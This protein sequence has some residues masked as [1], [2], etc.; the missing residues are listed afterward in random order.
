MTW[1]KVYKV[2]VS[3]Y[4]ISRSLSTRICPFRALL[5]SKTFKKWKTH[6]HYRKT[7][8]SRWALETIVWNKRNLI[9]HLVAKKKYLVVTISIKVRIPKSNTYPSILQIR[10]F[11]ELKV[12]VRILKVLEVICFWQARMIR[13]TSL[14]LRK[15]S[16]IWKCSSISIIWRFNRILLHESMTPLTKMGKLHLKILE[17]DQMIARWVFHFQVSE[18]NLT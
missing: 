2:R 14:T 18:E 16:T 9:S 1:V 15:A 13:V 12:Q 3:L 4:K 8:T 5:W 6:T 7:V 10:K 11:R 17:K